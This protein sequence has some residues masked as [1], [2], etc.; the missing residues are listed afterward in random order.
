MVK[1]LQNTQGI[2]LASEIDTCLIVELGQFFMVPIRDYNRQR[3]AAHH[4]LIGTRAT[5]YQ[6]L[7]QGNIPLLREIA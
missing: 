1:R 2:G 6:H 3:I 5:S 4:I 7:F